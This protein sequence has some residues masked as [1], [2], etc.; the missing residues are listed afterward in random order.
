MWFPGRGLGVSLISLATFVN[1]GSNTVPSM[2]SLTK[3]D[4]SILLINFLYDQLPS[5]HTNSNKL[6]QLILGKGMCPKFIKWCNSLQ[7]FPFWTGGEWAAIY[8]SGK[9][10]KCG[11]GV[12]VLQVGHF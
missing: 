6:Q 4:N 1:T 8:F 9:I 10:L 2:L 11:A 3:K 7:G 5:R 12:I